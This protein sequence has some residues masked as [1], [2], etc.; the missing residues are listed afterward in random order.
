M[1][2]LK[3]RH[4]Y[5][6]GAIILAGLVAAGCAKK[7]QNSP[8]VAEINNYRLTAEDFQVEALLSVP[9]VLKAEDVPAL[10]EQIYQDLLT[11]ELLVQEAQKS[12][13]DKD[14]HFMKEIEDYWKQALIKRIM[15]RK[16]NEYIR[17]STVSEEELKNAYA[18]LSRKIQAQM[19]YCKDKDSAA[20]LSKSGVNFDAVALQLKERILFSQAADFSAGEL[21]KPLED[22]LFSL[23]A[24]QISAPLEYNNTW[25]VFKAIGESQE[26]LKAYEQMVGQLKKMVLRK[27]VQDKLNRWVKNLKDSARVVR[28]DDVFQ[29]LKLN[30]AV[31]KKG[32]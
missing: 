1:N 9:D 8:V 25:V 18:L 27:K 3:K 13:L 7:E 26:N 28:H 19:V 17:T 24:G 30:A 4:Y 16:T 15:N 12:N 31:G 14:K 6:W 29:S 10:K 23:K 11:K 5:V 32:E 21:S 2:K 20:T 22:T